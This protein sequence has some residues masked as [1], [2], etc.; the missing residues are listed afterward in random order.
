MTTAP[1][2]NV[3]ALTKFL[4][5]YWPKLGIRRV[6]RQSGSDSSLYERAHELF[7]GVRR[8]DVFPTAAS[9]GFILV[10]NGSTAL[11]FHQDGDHFA[12]DGFEIGEYETGDVR[13]FDR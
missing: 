6:I 5:R 1:E 9:R 13:V 3:S 7:S 8:I 10:M 2:P 11:F 12:Y 4:L